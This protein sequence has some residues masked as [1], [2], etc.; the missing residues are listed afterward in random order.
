MHAILE[1]VALV[2]STE[3]EEEE[4]MAITAPGGQQEVGLGSDLQI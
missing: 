1:G 3:S 4:S 2:V